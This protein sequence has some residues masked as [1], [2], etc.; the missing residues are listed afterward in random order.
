LSSKTKQKTTTK[1]RFNQNQ[2]FY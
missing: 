1:E 2:V